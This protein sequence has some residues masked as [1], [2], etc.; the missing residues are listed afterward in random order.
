MIPIIV[1]EPNLIQAEELLEASSEF[2][3]DSG[4]GLE[5][6]PWRKV[7]PKNKTFIWIIIN[8]ICDTKR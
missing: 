1:E 5:D 4:S 6:S 7:G 2:Y 3:A 8:Y